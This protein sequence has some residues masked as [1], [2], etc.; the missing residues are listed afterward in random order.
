[1]NDI[2]VDALAEFVPGAVVIGDGSVTVGHITHDSRQARTGTLFACVAGAR[3]DGHDYA[4]AAL[5]LGA[6]ALLV[7]HVLPAIGSSVPQLIVPDVRKAMG[8]VAAAIYRHPSAS[9]RVVGVTGTNGKTSVVGLIGE[10][11]AHASVPVRMLGTLT[12]PRTTP[13]SPDL[14]ETFAHEVARGGDV[15]AMEVSSHALALHRVAGTQFVV[16]VF[17]NLGQDHL[18]FHG[19]LEQYEQAKTEL[20]SSRYI[21]KAIINTDDPAGRRIAAQCDVAVQ[22][23]GLA[24]AEELRIDG[25]VSQFRWGGHEIVFRLPG[26]HNVL[27]AL[28]AAFTCVE[29]GVDPL[30]IADALCNADGARGRFE[31]VNVGQPF[32]VVVDYAHKPEALQ[33]VINASRQIVGVRPDGSPGSVIVV[34]GCGGDRDPFKRPLMGAIAANFADLTV[35]TSDNPR[36]EDPS[37][38]LDQMEAGVPHDRRTT[39]TR[40]EDR[41]AAIAAALQSAQQG[42]VVLIAGKGDEIHQVIGDEAL[43]FD[44]REVA[45]AYLLGLASSRPAVTE[46]DHP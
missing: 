17:T 33:A 37:M 39:V 19:D 1:M 25:P 34:I 21:A 18:D 20:F 43:P 26:I 41:A 30:D 14:Q 23:Y 6:A 5:A 16:G 36:S 4:T 31:M 12:G 28:A 2:T 45:V 32:S 10:I 46:R 22:A 24:D 29:L 15:I 35:L 9:L 7:D 11:L 27:N 44:D 42:D 13:E 38:I 40:V 8:T 3:V